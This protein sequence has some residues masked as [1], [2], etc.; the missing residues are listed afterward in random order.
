MKCTIILFFHPFNSF[1]NLTL[2]EQSSVI[3][4]FYTLH[5][6]EISTEQL[7]DHSFLWIT[8]K[9]HWLYFRLGS[10]LLQS[11]QQIKTSSSPNFKY[12]TKSLWYGHGFTCGLSNTTPVFPQIILIDCWLGVF[13][14]LSRFFIQM[15]TL[16]SAGEGF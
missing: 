1:N 6:L 12:K 7:P 13:L 16:S 2:L 9:M 8:C 5:F 15:K 11:L 10:Q 14:S 4:Y 3:L